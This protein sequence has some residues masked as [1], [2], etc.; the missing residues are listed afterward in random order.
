LPQVALAIALARSEA[1]RITAFATRQAWQALD[2]A[3]LGH[4]I[5]KPHA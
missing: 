2:Q 1:S 4:S 3:A 5:R